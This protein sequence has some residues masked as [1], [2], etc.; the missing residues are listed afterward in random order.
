[1]KKYIYNLC[2]ES[3][4]SLSF[5]SL[6][7]HKHILW[8]VFGSDWVV[9]VSGGID[10]LRTEHKWTH[11]YASELVQC[12]LR[13]VASQNKK[14]CIHS[15]VINV[16]MLQLTEFDWDRAVGMLYA[17]M[18]VQTVPTALHVNESTILDLNGLSGKWIVTCTCATLAAA[19]H[20]LV[21]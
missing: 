19:P 4:H 3:F 5:L 1:M 12:I 13:T 11:L 20:H 16:T 14:Q 17:D 15:T 6:R 21:V 10:H 18:H 2:Y 9:L 7:V 8:V